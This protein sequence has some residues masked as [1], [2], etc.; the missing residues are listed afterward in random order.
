MFAG[1]HTRLRL[2]WTIIMLWVAMHT[3][4]SA[5]LTVVSQDFPDHGAI[6]QKFTCD[7]ENLPPQISIADVPSKTLGLALIME[8]P[9]APGGTFT[10]WIVFH[11]PAQ[12]R[13]LSQETVSQGAR[14]GRNDF[15]KTGYGGPCPPPGRAHHYLFHVYALDRQIELPDGATRKDLEQAMKGH[16]L[17]EGSLTG[18]YGRRQ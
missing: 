13:L 2:P 4:A 3:S 16:V 5:G 12:V 8:D 17:A 15:D 11:L 14:Q 10:H 1:I 18:L 9:D 6:P 7:G